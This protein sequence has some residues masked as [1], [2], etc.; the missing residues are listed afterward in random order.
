MVGAVLL[1]FAPLLVCQDSAFESERHGIRLRIPSDWRVDAA[2]R[3]ALLKLTLSGEYPFRPELLVYEVRPAE[4]VTLAQHKEKVRQ[5]LQAAYKEPRILDDRPIEAAG[6]PGFLFVVSSLAVTQTEAVSYK[7]MIE[8]S[9]RRL[10]AVE[11][12]FPRGSEA[13]LKPAYD[14]FL[15][16]L[17]FIPRSPPPGAE[18]G[19]KAYAEMRRKIAATAGAGDVQDDLKVYVGDK[20]IGALTIS[21]KRGRMNDVPGI[22]VETRTALEVDEQ[23]VE[24]RIRGFLSDDL[25]VQVVILDESRVGRD[26]RTQTFEASVTL[27]GAEAAVERRINGEPSSTKVKVPAGT[28]LAELAEVLQYRLLSLGRLSVSTPVLL[29]FENEPA[30]MQF[31]LGGVHKLK[32]EDKTAEVNVAFMTRAD[33]VLAN[34]WYDADL[35]LLRVGFSGQP[36]VIKR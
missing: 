3:D 13:A 11:A 26:K 23:R 17:E 22:D 15:A 32:V 24:T 27:V 18:A 9:P 4:P 1:L 30:W 6:R 31:E 10:V 28:I 20:Q 2:Q 14:E 12:V 25:T 21:Y 16:S 8:S 5:Y 33:G 36:L 35:K 29:S 7:A 34:Y 19:L